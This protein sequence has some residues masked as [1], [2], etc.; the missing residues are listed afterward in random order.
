MPLV[1]QR[2]PES[3]FVPPPSAGPD[4]RFMRPP[5][6][7][8]VDFKT[9]LSSSSL[10]STHVDSQYDWNRSEGSLLSLQ[11]AIDMVDHSR[12]SKAWHEMLASRWISATI[13]SVIPFYL[14][15]IFENCDALPALEILDGP[16]YPSS[17]ERCQQ[18]FDPELFRHLKHATVKDGAESSVTW[19]PDSEA[20]PHFI[21]S[22]ASMHLARMFAI[23]AS[24]KE[25]IWGAYNKLYCKDRRMPRPNDASGKTNVLTMREEFEYYWFNWEWLAFP[26]SFCPLDRC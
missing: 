4:S 5:D 15:A 24:C 25:A 13:T 12:L 7:R 11:Q 21:P 18:M 19:M 16:C 1:Q 14:S 23:V 22:H 2:L 9:I 17:S 8:S 3:G 10:S 26:P 20:P 6:S